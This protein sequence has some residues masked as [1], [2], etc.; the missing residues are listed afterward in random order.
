MCVLD[1]HKRLAPLKTLV[2]NPE[3]SRIHRLGQI[4]AQNQYVKLY[5]SMVYAKVFEGIR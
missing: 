1:Q 3:Y 4:M 2:F 5:T